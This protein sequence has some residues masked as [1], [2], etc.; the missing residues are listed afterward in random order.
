MRI[1]NRRIIAV[2]SATVIFA[3]LYFCGL[4]SS[5]VSLGRT[6][7][8]TED[9]WQASFWYLNGNLKGTLKTTSNE[10]ELIITSDLDKGNI[11]F[12]VYDSGNNLI[13]TAESSSMPDTIPNL[14]RGTIYHVQ[15]V[16]DG[17]KGTFKL[18]IQ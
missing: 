17:A 13:G 18:N 14:Q 2:V 8:N 4:L 11:K 15:A 10:S 1:K 7:V 3:V 6:S 5:R 12:S 16:A 9:E